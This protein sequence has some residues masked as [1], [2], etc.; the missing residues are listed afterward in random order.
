MSFTADNPTFRGDKADSQREAS[1]SPA[2]S[3]SSEQE[4][5]PS[6]LDNANSQ[7]EA[8]ASPAPSQSSEQEQQSSSLDE[9][10]SQSE[11]SASPTP[12]Q[13]WEQEQYD[14][15]WGRRR[16]GSAS[17]AVSEESE[18]PNIVTIDPGVRVPEVLTSLK[19]LYGTYAEPFEPVALRWP[20]AKCGEWPDPGKFVDLIKQAAFS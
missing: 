6:S 15:Y 7:R 9:A 3:Q 4:Q 16:K 17:P 11:A 19:A 5:Q 2:P 20:G 13:K 10:D 14:E 8:S 18:M 1:A 12:S